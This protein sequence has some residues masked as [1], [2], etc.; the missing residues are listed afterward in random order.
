M[1]NYGNGIQ[2]FARKVL[3]NSIKPV[4]R[5]L[6]D[7]LKYG[8][9]DIFR[10]V[11][12]EI[13]T[14]CNYNKCIYCPNS[15]YD[16]SLPENN[17]ILETSV[18]QNVINQLEAMDFRGR[19]SPVRFNEP[20]SDG[21]LLELMTYSKE[22]LPKAKN[23]VYTNGHLL[24]PEKYDELKSVV[25]SFMVTAHSNPLSD[26]LED[27]FDYLEIPEKLLLKDKWEY[28]KISF[29]RHTD[30]TEITNRGGLIAFN[31]AYK[32]RGED[33]C[34]HKKLDGLIVDYT[35]NILACCEDYFGILKFGN[36]K[37]EKIMGIWNKPSFVKFRREAKHGV[38]SSEICKKCAQGKMEDL[39][40]NDKET[41]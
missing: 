32:S 34:I 2:G 5:P 10:Y 28:K 27:L 33:K 23:V 20:L 11:D 18:F 17:K 16:R 14:A 25:D 19:I 29:N 39:I 24:K 36:V 4:I 38:L 6:Y 31:K 8:T 15:L 12:I 30:N 22:R 26:S 7:F 1:I 35:G 40:R 9:T 37:E 41:T 3:R 21:R 13:S